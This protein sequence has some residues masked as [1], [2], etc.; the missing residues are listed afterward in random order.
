MFDYESQDETPQDPVQKYKITFFFPILDTIINSLTERFD[1][2]TR[3]A[4]K[5]HFLSDFNIICTIDDEEL[6]KKL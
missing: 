4:E 5:F 2:L 1:L 6:K 3:H